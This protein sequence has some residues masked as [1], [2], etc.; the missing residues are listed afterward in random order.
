ML[1]PGGVAIVGFTNA[2]FL[3]DGHEGAQLKL[4]K[5]FNDAQH[6]WTVGAYFQFSAGAGWKGLAGYDLIPAPSAI[7]LAKPGFVA[8][9]QLMLVQARENARARSNARAGARALS[10]RKPCP[11]FS[12]TRARAARRG[13][14]RRRTR[15]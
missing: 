2:K 12:L 3:K 7:E 11:S 9:Q 1:K 8:K 13:A 4:W 6:I 10:P 15:W 5:E 14:R